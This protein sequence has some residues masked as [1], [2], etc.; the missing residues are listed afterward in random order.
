MYALQ[1][2]IRPKCFNNRFWTGQDYSDDPE[3]ILKFTTADDV[4]RWLR[5]H[6]HLRG[7]LKPVEIQITEGTVTDANQT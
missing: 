3:K 7:Y 6:H 1:S 2:K 4:D 5:T